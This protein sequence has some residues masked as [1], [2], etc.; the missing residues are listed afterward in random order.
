MAN[1]LSIQSAVSVGHVGNE[2]ACFALQRLGVEV[3]R[4]DTVHLSNHPGHGPA[5]GRVRGADE[6]R[7][8][9][10]GIAAH[11]ALAR[12]DAVLS[13]YLGS[14]ANGRVVADTVLR[15]RALR[16]GALYAC[17]PV[18]G[19]HGRV[20]VAQDIPALFADLLCPL[21]DILLPNAFELGVLAGRPQG[22]ADLAAARADLAALRAGLSPAGPRL[23]AATGLALGD[24]QM[25]SLLA[26][27]AGLFGCAA[28]LLPRQF[29][30]AG[31]VFGA[32]FLAALLRGGAPA[33]AL[34]QACGMTA[35]LLQATAAAGEAELALVAAQA[36]WS[37]AAPLPVRQIG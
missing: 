9:I 32:F 5:A 16:P 17:D 13:G 3:W 18:M 4:A 15:A 14:A 8:L 10:D 2:A 31:D 24:G 12:V 35:A 1:I 29:S 33:Q 34:G 27:E 30:G 20:Y 7:Q 22:A 36:G 25:L 19:D 6:L 26:C 23:V 37:A 28:P 21:A 11:G